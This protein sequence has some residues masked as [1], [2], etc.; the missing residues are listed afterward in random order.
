MDSSVV[1]AKWRQCAPH[2]LMLPWTHPSPSG[3]S[4]GSAFLHS[5]QQ[6]VPILHNGPPLF[7]RQNCPFA[8]GIWTFDLIGSPRPCPVSERLDKQLSRKKFRFIRINWTENFR[9]AKRSLTGHGCSLKH[10]LCTRPVCVCDSVLHGD[11]L[12]RE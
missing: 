3:I 6:S 2:L 12:S 11:Q 8:W 9:L 7:S 5:S 1:F 4:I 10:M